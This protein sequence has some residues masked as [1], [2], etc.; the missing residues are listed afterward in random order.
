M[1]C[2]CARGALA[3][4]LL[5]A[6]CDRVVHAQLAP[7]RLVQVDGRNMRI[8]AQGLESRKPGQPVLL[9][10]AGGGYTLDTWTQAFPEIARLAPTLAYDRRGLGQSEFDGSRPTFQHRATSLHALLQAMNVAPPYVLVGQSL[11][12]VIIRAFAAA[13]PSEVVGLVYVE[14]PDYEATRQQRAAALPPHERAA[15]LAPPNVPP[16]PANVA[17]GPRAEMEYIIENVLNDYADARTLAP[18]PSVPA[19]VIIAAPPDRVRNTGEMLRLQIAHQ[20]EWSLTSPKGLFLVANHVGH[21]A[22]RD[23]PGLVARV[24]THV[25]DSIATPGP[26]RN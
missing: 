12:G 10:E 4:W 20:M 23:D 6:A 21:M 11:G 14:V 2:R 26:A 17:P 22:H 8:A 7:T 24:V 25:L 13:Y 15:A 1:M 18:P 19:A 5:L 16:I 3:G 9:L